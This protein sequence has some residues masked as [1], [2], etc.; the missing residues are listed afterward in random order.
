MPEHPGVSVRVHP[1]VR[2]GAPVVQLDGVQGATLP[3]ARWPRIIDPHR[4]RVHPEGT[5]P[6]RAH[7]KERPLQVGRERTLHRQRR[8]GG[9]PAHHIPLTASP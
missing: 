2:D 6:T 7:A 1:Y 5:C 9:D 8:H 3:N 4:T